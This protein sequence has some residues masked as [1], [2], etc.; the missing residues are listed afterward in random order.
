MYLI[1][2]FLENSDYDSPFASTPNYGLPLYFSLS[3]TLFN[4]LRFLIVAPYLAWQLVIAVLDR[5]STTDIIHDIVSPKMPLLEIENIIFHSLH[6][7]EEFKPSLPYA[8]TWDIMGIVVEI[9]RQVSLALRSN[10]LN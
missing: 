2:L 9:Y 4:A 7:L 8:G 5:R 1:V 6:M 10:I 3:T